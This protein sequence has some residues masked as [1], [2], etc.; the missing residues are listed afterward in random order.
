MANIESKNLLVAVKAYSRGNALPLDAS[1]VYDSLAAAQAYAKEANAYAGQ[2]IK[3]LEDG[4][5]KS[6]VLQPGANGFTLEPVGAVQ[7]SDLDV[8]AKLK[9]LENYTQTKDLKKYVQVVDALPTA[10]EEN[11]LYL[12]GTDV[13]E[14]N[15]AGEEVLVDTK[16]TGSIWVKD[17]ESGKYETVIKDSIDIEKSIEDI[18]A[19]IEDIND[20]LDTKAPIENPTFTGTVKVE[21]TVD[22]TTVTEEVALKSEVETKANTL[23]PVFLGTV[24]IKADETVADADAE[25]VAVK[26]YVDGLIAGIHSN[27]P[28]IVNSENPLPTNKYKAG[29][30]WRVSEAGTYAGQKCEVG[31][32]IICLNDYKAS[33]ASN[34]DFLVVQ[35]NIDGAVTSNADAVT[36]ASIVVFDGV[37]GKVIKSSEVSLSSLNN[38][39]A[40]SHTHS[41]KAKLDT[42]DKTQSELLEAAAGTA[43]DKVDDLKRDVIDP[44]FEILPIK[45]E[46]NVKSLDVYTKEEADDLFAEAATT[47][48][49]D[50]VDGIVDDAKKEASDGLNDLFEILPI[51]EVG[52]GEDKTKE[53][54]VYT[55]EEI[56]AVI[57]TDGSLTANVNTKT[58]MKDVKDYIGEIGTDTVKTYIDNAVGNVDIDGAIVDAIGTMPIDDNGDKQTVKDYVDAGLAGKAD[59]AT[60]I[61]G[62]GITDAYTKEE[63]NNKVSSDIGAAKSELQGAIDGKVAQGDFDTLEGKVNT[64]IGTEK[65]DEGNLVDANKSVRTIANEEIAAKLISTDAKESLDTLAEIAAW[66]QKH[67][68]DA[69]AMNESIAAIQKQLQG[70][71]AGEGTVKKYI[72][73]AVAAKDL[74]AY[75]TITYSDAQDEATLNAAKAYTNAALTIVRF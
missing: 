32:V 41:N 64:L 50:E 4:K 6:Y 11:V 29:N 55:K 10:G 25:E 36:D 18:L 7:A 56:D 71:A 42:Y 62:Y 8:Y 14:T 2:T 20:V 68:E 34:N 12:V 65:D 28:K 13:K 51:K 59:T 3:V 22:G 40:D 67:P 24:K 21:N 17:G 19:D 70:I 35:A 38:V 66:I 49:K 54:N 39:I 31:D 46:N 73:D 61:A 9:D 43:Q 57:G 74:S 30:T 69:A 52:E 58:T 53:L 37:T 72:D 44:V 60:T 48:T 23:N 47:Y 75:A 16:W 33:E 26:S 15:D 5:Y 27:T 45:E 63:V 1:E